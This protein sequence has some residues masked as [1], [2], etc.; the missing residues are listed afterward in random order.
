[1]GKE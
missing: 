1:R